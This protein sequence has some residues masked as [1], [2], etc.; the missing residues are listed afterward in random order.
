[1]SFWSERKVVV[2]GGAGFLGSFIVEALR[3]KGSDEIFVPRSRDY[4]LRKEDDV[5]RMFED[6]QPDLVI[7]AA[8]SVGGIGANSANPGKFFYDNAMMGM[9]IIEVARRVGL[10]KLVLVGTVCS[11]PKQ[12][13][14]IREEDL[15]SGYPEETNGPYGM[16][17]KMHLVQ[18]QAYRQQYGLNA[19]Y[20]ILA[21]LYGPGESFDP[22]DSHV[23]A[24]LVRKFL[25]ARSQGDATVELWGDGSPT[26][27]F[28][29]VEDAAEGILQAAES[30]DG[31]EP[32]NLGTGQETSIKM[33]AE[34]IVRLTGFQG[35]LAWDV[36][37]PNGQPRRL[38]DATRAAQLFGF[39]PRTDLEEGLR[40]E[41]NW[42]T[43]KAL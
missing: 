21:N 43:E 26:R 38:V 28:L 34:T 17:K 22:E 36:S 11:Y 13:E 4:D 30:Y 25:D 19:I 20:L 6:A 1:M 16:S 23:T 29:Y 41:L 10:Q 24:A 12:L 37:K 35:R 15:W 2:T 31:S 40:R 3:K 7:H 33:L 18:A 27:D 14:W 8:G 32:V 39:H 5:T 9:H 42:Y